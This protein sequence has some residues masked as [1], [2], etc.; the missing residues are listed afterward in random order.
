MLK[1]TEITQNDHEKP[2]LEQGKPGVFPEL[3]IQKRSWVSAW[4]A[5]PLGKVGND[6]DRD[7]KIRYRGQELV[8]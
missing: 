7:L 1:P 8:H 6:D 4:E 2:D 5:C 3:E